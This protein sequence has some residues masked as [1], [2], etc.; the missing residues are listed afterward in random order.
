[1]DTIPGYILMGTLLGFLTGLGVGGGSLLILWLTQVLA[2]PQAQA[3]GINLLFFLPSALVACLF[4]GRQ[5]RLRRDVAIPAMIAG[6]VAA[7]LCAWLAAGLD[8]KVLKKIFSFLLLAAGLWE[9][10]A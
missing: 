4:A 2:V 9:M 7:A 8:E 3:Q 1:M 10:K 6:A 5:G